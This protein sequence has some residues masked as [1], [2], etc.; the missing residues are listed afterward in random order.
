MKNNRI[1]A[2]FNNHY[3]WIFIIL[4]ITFVVYT[5]LFQNDLLNTW[6]DDRYIL[7][8]QLIQNNSVDGL[9]EMFTSY[10]DGHYHP[11]TL[12][13]LSIDYQIG[14]FNPIVYHTTNL[15]L[16]LLNTILVFIFVWFLF[17]KRNIRIAIFTSLLFGLA[18]INV[19]SV[20]WASERKNLLY[21]LF[22]WS[23]LIA[24]IK[25]LKKSGTGF[26]ILAIILFVFSS[27]SK[28]MAIPLCFALPLI[29]YFYERKLLS[30]KLILEKIPF[31]AIAFIVGIVSIVA[32]QSTWGEG[33][34]QQ[35]YPFYERILFA[36]FAF[37][38]YIFKSIVPIE[39]VGF[40]PYPA[41][42][43]TAIILKYIFSL[44]LILGL[45]FLFIKK[46]KTSKTFTFSL[47]FFSVNIFLLLKLF[48][49][50]AGDYIMADRYNYVAGVGLFL[51]VGYGFNY[52]LETFL[53][54]RIILLAL[55]SVYL[56]LIF[57]S[58][59]EQVKVWE[60]DLSFYSHI[61]NHQPNAQLAFLNRGGIRKEQG[62]L[63]GA[64]SDFNKAIKL[65][66]EDYKA[67]SNRGAVYT[68]LG[69]HAKALNDYQKADRLKP[70]NP[71]ILGNFGYSQLKTGQFNEAI[72]TLTQSLKINNNNAE[73]LTNLGTA[74]YSLGNLHEAIVD[75][76][77]AIEIDPDYL[78]AH[79]NLGLAW[80]NLGDFPR[81]INSF[82]KT[83]LLKPDYSE[84]YSNLAIAWSRS[85]NM[86]NALKNYNNA[87][88]LN[89]SN[90]E[91]YLN[92]GIDYYFHND[93]KNAITDINKSISLN[94]N[95]GASY[96]FR[97]MTLLKSG[98]TP[99]CKDL[100]T[101]LK[102]GFTRASRE[103][104]I[105]CR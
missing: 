6:D 94:P 61:I 69:E 95:L 101:A 42:L 50:P 79:F 78:N 17:Q 84:A 66:P 77:K 28:A 71:D 44:F 31:F 86:E 16:H 27:L 96:Y 70:N 82:N 100:Q 10:Y 104:N 23:T 5:P 54:Y 40:Y 53:K 83:I 58:T 72:K 7:E 59:F 88:D 85:G 37:F 45:I 90:Y 55:F 48:E 62:N 74:K 4:V 46:F 92:R 1:K 73:V 33:L 11:L 99:P 14:E 52:L 97:A 93:Y 22:Y 39:L 65:K 25:Y 80:L 43:E 51:F 32:Q 3:L 24:Y 49:V 12:V 60:N 57:Y 105:H 29:D 9:I 8:N 35:D 68:D 26:Y 47:L 18:T 30:K 63:K 64:L 20:A 56:G 98:N 21:T 89:P 41:T 13:S 15:I 2:I 34:S 91:V 36:G 19:E 103:L 87:L 67:N 102:L 75:Y 76:G 38:Q 81:A